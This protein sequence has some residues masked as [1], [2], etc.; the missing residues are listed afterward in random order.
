MAR[1]RTV[2]PEFFTNHKLFKAEKDFKLPLRVSFAGL[3]CHADREGRFKWIPEELK[4]GILP[5]DNI[6]FSRVL[7]ALWTRG[8][9]EKYT[10]FDEFFGWIPSFLEH[11]V[12]NNRERES[13]LPIPNENNTLTCEARVKGL[14]STRV[15]RQQ[16]G[17]EGKGREGKGTTRDKHTIPPTLEEI[18]NYCKQRSNSVDPEKFFNHYEA[19]GWMIGKNKMKDWQ[20]SV[21]T[22][23]KNTDTPHEPVVRAFP[24]V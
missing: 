1:I 21:H 8:Y 12:V 3:W 5:Y 9:I 17:R 4:I 20:A 13:N 11:Q 14:S 2:K 19:K 7:D 6:D 22:W 23:E 10:C 15:A 16:S 24:N 18:K